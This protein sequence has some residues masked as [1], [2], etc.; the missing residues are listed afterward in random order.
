IHT[1]PVLSLQDISMVLWS[2]ASLEPSP[3]PLEWIHRLTTQLPVS[4]FDSFPPQ[5]LSNSLWAL[6]RLGYQPPAVWLGAV[7]GASERRLES[8][9]TPELVNLL[10]AF[11][12]L[13]HNP[14][15][16]WMAGALG[17]LRDRA[18][19]MSPQDVSTLCWSLA[20]M[21]V[22]PGLPLLQR[23]VARALAVRRVMGPQSLVNTLWG[24]SRLRVQLPERAVAL[25]LEGGLGATALYGTPNTMTSRS[26]CAGA[27]GSGRY[28]RSVFDIAP[29]PPRVA[30]AAVAA[31]PAEL[32]GTA[33]VLAHCRHVPPYSWLIRYCSA[34]ARQLH[35][36]G[37]RELST[38]LYGIGRLGPL[39]LRVDSRW[40]DRLLTAV[41]QM[42]AAAAPSLLSPPLVPMQSDSCTE[43]P[44]KAVRH[45]PKVE[46]VAATVAV[47]GGGGTGS[48]VQDNQAVMAVA[49]GAAFADEE[50]HE[51]AAAVRAAV[52]S[53]V[54]SISTQFSTAAL[55]PPL[56]LP[57]RRRQVEKQPPPPSPEHQPQ[58]RE[59]ER[60]SA[61]QIAIVLWAV[62]RLGHNPPE[63]WV[64]T[65]ARQVAARLE[66]LEAREIA[67]TI[68]A[69]QELAPAG[70][71]AGPS[72]T[73]VFW[74][75]TATSPSYVRSNSS[76]V[77]KWRGRDSGR[78]G[79]SNGGSCS[80]GS[81]NINTRNSSC[82]EAVAGLI[83][84]L[85]SKL[86]ERNLYGT[87]RAASLSNGGMS[88]ATVAD[89]L[90]TDVYSV[91]SL[92]LLGGKELMRRG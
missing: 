66:E 55:R 60:I 4:L 51:C 54:H 43:P 35:L 31:S 1:R 37:P 13:R 82:G 21:K 9:T 3:P 15:R 11:A 24:L 30:A 91:K 25:L 23:L 52:H 92:G 28:S 36:F 45:R 83:T 39:G 80:N 7:A 73:V 33:L 10:W 85:V 63:A 50:H 77:R 17:L 12:V 19:G 27:S 5:A 90:L 78:T 14:G 88:Y 53:D 68:R 64:T 57:A 69:L 26:S 6:A 74:R 71:P 8:F 76:S 46:A 81:S 62:A 84:R 42:A 70:G 87:L 59:S 18:T 41:E 2:L 38:L 22:R 48:A 79:G 89:Q 61:S 16:S 32:A 34:V 86:P 65:M 47:G 75:R 29:R 40:L 67:T 20:V 56:Q 72:D 58:R 44:G 49:A